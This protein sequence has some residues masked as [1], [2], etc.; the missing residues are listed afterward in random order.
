MKKALHTVKEKLFQKEEKQLSEKQLKRIAFLNKYS[1]IFHA[2]LSCALVFVVEWIS[3]RSFTSAVSFVAGS[4]G[5]YFYNALIVFVSLMLVYLFRRRAFARTVISAFWLLLGIINGLILSN[6]VTPF[7]FTDIKCIGDLFAMTN[8][9]YFTAEEATMVVIGLGIFAFFCVIFFIKGP[10]FAGKKHPI[11]LMLVLAVTVFVGVPVTTQAAQDSNVLASYFSNIAQGYE[12]Y[13]FIYG[14]SSS[15]V[16]I[17]MDKPDNYSEETI[18]EINETVDQ[19]LEE[20]Y[21]IEP[22]TED[23]DEAAVAEAEESIYDSEDSTE[24]AEEK[25]I[26]STDSNPNIILILLESFVDPEDILLFETEEDPVPTFHYLEENYTSGY[27]TVPVVGAG[28]ANTEFEVL[29]GMSMQYFGTGEYPYKTILKKIDSCESI[30][31]VLSSIGYSTHAVHNNGGNFYSRVNAFSMFGFDTFT[32]K[33]LMDITDWTATGS[34]P[35]DDILVSETIKTLDATPDQADFTYTITV[36]THGD[37]PETEVLD[38]VLYPVIGFEDEGTTNSWNYYVNQL[39]EVDNFLAALIEELSERDEDTI[40]IAFGD[41]LPTMNLTEEDMASGDIY[42]TKYVTWNNFGLEKEDADLYA[43][44]LMAYMTDQLDIH[45][46]T[47]MTYHQ[48]QS[49]SETYDEG[50]EL[51]QYDLLYGSRYSYG[52]DD[53]YP[54]TDIVM[55][56][57]E[58]VINLVEADEESS[59]LI[60]YG[61]GFTNWSK[62]YVNGTKVK[63]TYISGTSLSISLDKVAYGDTITVCQVGSSSTIFRE[64]NEYV[65][66]APSAVKEEESEETVIS[67]IEALYKGEATVE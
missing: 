44:Q 12:N 10:R 11:F 57:D 33:E 24:E 49:E 21:G 50:L 56:I 4:T 6:R 13:G 15:V 62:V 40:V 29:T 37:Y 18:D 9:S 39:H 63:T 66:E 60:L 22:S 27:L 30:A 17:G 26:A 32:S 35:T 3:R 61:S 48:T 54:A 42:K 64:S 58:V 5:A 31:S 65:Y 38:E 53:P 52:D 67:P 41:H 14:F 1:I 47:I 20:M 25:V 2:L 45:E 51:L 59:K 8:T 34:W 7:G 46:G 36:S 43:Y 16:G 19:V 28:T 23:T 55:G